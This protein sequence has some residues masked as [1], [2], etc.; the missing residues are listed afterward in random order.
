MPT[1]AVAQEWDDNV[2]LAGEGSNG[3]EDYVTAV[4]PSLALG[5]RGRRTTLASDYYGLF[6]FYRELS[7]FNSTAQGGQV[8][9][10]QRVSRRL[11]LFARD[12]VTMA[13]TTE[14]I[15]AA[16][17][18]LRR[19]TT[20]F[21]TFRGGLEITMGERTSLTT[22]YSSQWI[23]F[24]R[25]ETVAPLLRGGHSHGGSLELRHT[26]TSRVS[27]GTDYDYQHAIVAHGGD[28]FDIQ[29]AAANVEL[30]LTRGLALTAEGGYA[31]LS[32]GRDQ[33]RRDAPTFRVGLGWTHPRLSWD[34]AYGRA[35]LPSFGFGGTTQNE[36]IVGSIRVPMT[37]RFDWSSSVAAHD[38]D[39][40]M[41]GDTSLRSISAHT[42]FVFRATRWMSVQA[43]G[44][45]AFQDSHLAGGRINRT[46]A[47]IQVATSRSLRVR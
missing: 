47:G 33:V 26:L 34:V 41:A 32:P 36:E 13:P 31:W 7:G 39:P 21:N 16:A 8:E 3:P 28:E 23:A 25:D 6:D 22:A 24:A 35:F 38:N 30:S 18:V 17:L 40:L 11:N 44:S 27:I 5:F 42:S 10:T 43:F 29:N 2:A 4:R 12:N 9:L 1:L 45:Y 46:R 37:S 15:D 20:R 19:R 14:D